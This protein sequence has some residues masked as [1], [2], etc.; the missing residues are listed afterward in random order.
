M[1][2]L[3]EL[4][5]SVL[6]EGREWTRQQLQVRLQRA[7][8]AVPVVCP[9]RGQPLRAVR[10]VTLPLQTP[11]GEI[12]LQV[13]YGRSPLTRQWHHPVRQAWQLA[14]H[15][16]TSPELTRRLTQTA[17]WINSYEKAARVATP[18]GCPISDDLV[19]D[20]VQR[21]GG[22]RSR[23]RRSGRPRLRPKNR[24]SPW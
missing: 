4:E 16:R 15:Q 18:W 22:T 23:P 9:H 8:A 12:E 11:V 21:G 13:P 3:L 2:P 20:L 6:D 10:T 24:P 14:P 19:R 1:N 17:P 7:A 5:T